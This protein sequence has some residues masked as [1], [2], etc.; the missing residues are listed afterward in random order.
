VSDRVPLTL[1]THVGYITPHANWSDPLNPTDPWNGYPYQ[2]EV[3][4][5]VQSQSHSDPT[6]IRPFTYNGLDVGIGDWLVFTSSAMALEV[7]SIVSQTDSTLTFIVEDVG[8]SNLLNNPAQTGQGI[9]PVSGSETYDCLIINLNSSGVPI[10]A[11]LPD[12]SVPINLVADITNRFQ[13]RNY[14]QDYIPVTQPGNSLQVGDIIW[15]DVDGTYY[16]AIASTPGSAQR[17]GE[18]TSINQPSTGDFT[19]R[20]LNRY[21]K[22]LPALPGLP[23]EVLYVSETTPG[24]LTNIPPTSES[25]IPVYIKI[26]SSSAI[27]FGGGG[28]GGASGNL[29]ISG[30]DIFAT[31][32]NGN[33]GLVP[34]GNG[35][36][37]ISGLGEGKLVLAG[38]GNSLVTSNLYTYD[39]NNETLSV[40]N[41]EINSEFISTKT[42]GVPLILTAN[43]ANVQI[44][45]TADLTGN[46]II[47]LQDP[48]EDQDAATKH[49]VDAVAQGLST[50]EA[51]R[52]GT[53]AELDA[54][55][56]PLVS[57]GSL[58]SNVYQ[59]IEIDTVEPDINDRILVKNQSDETQ[60]GIY[61][62]VQIGG[63]SQP[64]IL[65]RTSDFNGQGIAGQ[66]SAGD[67]VFVTEGYQNGGTGW[68][69][70]TPNPV[71]VNVSPIH[72]TQF[73]AAGVIQAGFGLTK[74]GTILDVNVAPIIN[75]NTGLNTS[76]GPLGYKIIELNIDPAAPLE[77]YGGALRVK[78]SI[79]GIGLSYDMLAGNISVNSNQPTIIGL[80]NV[81]SG[82]WSANVIATQ[83]GG[84]GNSVIGF[85]AQSLV[86]NDDGTGTKWE[87]RSKLTES[88]M[89]PFYPAPADGDRWF[90][91][92]T[93][94]LFTRVTDTNGGHWVEL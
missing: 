17:V 86:V 73:S 8:L 53:T 10:F 43:A 93:G 47:N 90:N 79:A 74:T 33:I 27:M 21:V 41:V 37:T 81:T 12:Y 54:T 48:I 29:N 14:I 20:P 4:V 56:T 18:V 76:V 85:P 35:V 38:P 24:A 7:V 11:P 80:G 57:Y 26:T 23:G 6:T 61:R 91:T 5:E 78:G 1:F 87:Y 2:W 59:R 31:N 94:I 52:A 34:Q 63:P 60:N 58:T 32:E 84:T 30:N 19:Y 39:V 40:G 22:N 9:G 15:L 45:T 69:Q 13:F 42:A 46:R 64:W 44:I 50:K 68:V 77:V 82:T 65:S 88:S 89:P 49:Y 70:T 75:T 71:T 62:V 67:F 83:Y 3:S 55:F 16:P 25:A 51:V 66:I 92:D 72:W 28:G 36:V